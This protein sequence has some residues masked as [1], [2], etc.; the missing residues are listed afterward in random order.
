[1]IPTMGT[2][3]LLMV[4]LGMFQMMHSGNNGSLEQAHSLKAS[5]CHN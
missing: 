5:I 1:M 4:F 3:L 2:V